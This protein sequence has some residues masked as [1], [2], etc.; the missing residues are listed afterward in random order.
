MQHNPVSTK[1]IAAESRKVPTPRYW[2]GETEN[3]SQDDQ[4]SGDPN[5]KRV[6]ILAVRALKGSKNRLPTL[7]YDM[8]WR[9]CRPRGRVVTLVCGRMK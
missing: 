6:V 4:S 9:V 3:R 8:K 7:P 2:N 5:D 1:P